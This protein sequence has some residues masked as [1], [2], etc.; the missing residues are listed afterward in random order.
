M[1]ADPWRKMINRARPFQI[2]WQLN[3]EHDRVLPTALCSG[4]ILFRNV[5]GYRQNVPLRPV[6]TYDPS[7]TS[8]FRLFGRQAIAKLTLNFFKVPL[9]V[10]T[11]FNVRIRLG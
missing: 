10:V 7:H 5:L 9:G 1:S 4:K 11:V 8:L 3:E 6:G 2:A